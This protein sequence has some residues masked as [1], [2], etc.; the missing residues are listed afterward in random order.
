MSVHAHARAR[1]RARNTVETMRSLIY[2]LVKCDRNYRFATHF[3]SC[4]SSRRSTTNMYLRNALKYSNKTSRFIRCPNKISWHAATATILRFL[5]SFTVRTKGIVREFA[6][7]DSWTIKATGGLVSLI[8]R[9]VVCTK[10][11]NGCYLCI[12][13][14][15][16]PPTK[17]KKQRRNKDASLRTR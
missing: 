6:R 2:C 12:N 5:P 15:V 13:D 4:T 1:A 3:I 10:Q 17:R 14:K 11:N 9:V 7:F 8:V 16:V